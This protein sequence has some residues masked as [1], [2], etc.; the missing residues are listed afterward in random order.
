M[1]LEYLGQSQG[2]LSTLNT[3]VFLPH[4]LYVPYTIG[5]HILLKWNLSKEVVIRFLWRRTPELQKQSLSPSQITVVGGGK[6]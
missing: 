3:N 5:L 2:L 6:T 4:P 1:V